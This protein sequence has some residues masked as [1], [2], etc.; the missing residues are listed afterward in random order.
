VPGFRTAAYLTAGILKLPALKLLITDLI[1]V[2]MS[3]ALMFGLGYL[4]ADQI[5]RG[6]HEV[7]QWV[8]VILVAGVL[9]WVLYR[10]ERAR[11]QAG[12]AVGPPVLDVDEAPLPTLDEAPGVEVA[13]PVSASSAGEPAEGIGE[14]IGP[15]SAARSPA[16]ADGPVDIDLAPP[17]TPTT[18]QSPS[19]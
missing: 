3:T 17:A 15:A 5:Q 10:Y 13:P 8:T 11:R 16:G 19:R 4:F 12:K 1:A 14:S 6:I 18:V 9:G 2:S 7:Q